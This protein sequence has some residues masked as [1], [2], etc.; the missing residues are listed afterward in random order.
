VPAKKGHLELEAVVFGIPDQNAPEIEGE[1]KAVAD[2]LP[3]SELLV[4][5]KATAEAL[6]ARGPFAGLVH[7]AT[8]GT[9]RQG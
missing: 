5:E 1:V 3:G 4:G 8:H 7:I 2:M 9:Y 6:R